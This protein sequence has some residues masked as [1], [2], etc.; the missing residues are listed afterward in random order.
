MAWYFTLVAECGDMR[1]AADEFCQHFHTL[2]IVLDSGKRIRC[3]AAVDPQ[4][5]QG[6]W[7]GIVVP[8]GYR[9]PFA[10]AGQ[11]YARSGQEIAA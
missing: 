1:A 11:P 9:Y 8:S 4:D 2:D 10:A 6:N 7:W 3:S 5:G